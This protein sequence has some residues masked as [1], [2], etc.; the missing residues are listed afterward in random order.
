M[1]EEGPDH[2]ENGDD[3]VGVEPF[4]GAV[5]GP[6]FFRFEFDRFSVQGDQGFPDW[7]GV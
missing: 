6:F 3:L 7:S 1:P 5:C 4:S 2:S